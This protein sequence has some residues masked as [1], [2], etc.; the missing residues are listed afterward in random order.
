M[1]PLIIPDRKSPETSKI[2]IW[3]KFHVSI[4]TLVQIHKTWDN[5]LTLLEIDINS[6]CSDTVS[7][8]FFWSEDHFEFLKMQCHDIV[9]KK[10]MDR[11]LAMNF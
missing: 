10:F 4:K 5:L 3:L 2:K 7:K 9:G 6:D 11:K 1:I 8:T